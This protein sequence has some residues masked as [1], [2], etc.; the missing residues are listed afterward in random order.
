M[1]ILT[2]MYKHFFALVEVQ[3]NNTTLISNANRFILFVPV[4]RH[5]H[6]GAYISILWNCCGDL[7]LFT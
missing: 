7:S 4:E 2:F 5:V 6:I 1:S 3:S